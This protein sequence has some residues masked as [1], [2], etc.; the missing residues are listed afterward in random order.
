[1]PNLAF[2]Q[3]SQSVFNTFNTDRESLDHRLDAMEGKK[4]QH[5]SVKQIR[6]EYGVLKR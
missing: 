4:L 5:L 6:L 1:M 3:L 2:V